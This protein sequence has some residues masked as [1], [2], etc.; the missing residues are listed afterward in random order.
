MEAGHLEGLI[1]LALGA[2]TSLVAAGIVKTRKGPGAN[3]AF[4]KKARRLFI[5]VTIF[6]LDRGGTYVARPYW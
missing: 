1:C 2:C 5:L 4:L 6:L 3:G